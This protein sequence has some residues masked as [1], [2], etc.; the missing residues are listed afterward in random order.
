MRVSINEFR[1]MLPRY[2]VRNLPQYNAETAWDTKIGSGELRCLK[3]D[4]RMFR[5]PDVADGERYE[6]IYKY[7]DGTPGGRWLAWTDFVDLTPGPVDNDAYNRMYLTGLDKP[8]FFDS[9]MLG[10]A[11]ATVDSSNSYS[12]GVTAPLKPTMEVSGTGTGDT[13]S[14]SYLVTYVRELADGRQD[15]SGPSPVATRVTGE[16]FVDVASGQTVILT[17]LTP[18]S[19]TDEG[20]I[21]YIRVYRT[22]TSTAGTAMY[23]FVYEFST[24]PSE[25]ATYTKVTWDGSKFTFTDDV[26]D[27]DLAEALASTDWN[28]PPDNLSGLVY[29]RNGVMAGFVGNDVYFCEPYKPHAWPTKYKL[30]MAYSI[31]GLGVFGNNLVICTDAYP[32]VASVKTPDSVL[33]MPIN[34]LAP[35]LSK[36]SIV[37]TNGAVYYATSRGL[38]RIDTSTPTLVTHDFFLA[39]DWQELNP[40]S[41]D[42]V[43]HR[44]KYLVFFENL[45]GF[46]GGMIIEL[47]DQLNGVTYISNYSDSAFVEPSTDTL[48]MVSRISPQEHYVVKFEGEPNMRKQTVWKSKE[49]TLPEG[50]GNMAAA[51]VTL[52]QC[53]DNEVIIDT[54]VDLMGELGGHVIG[55]LPVAGDVYTYLTSRVFGASNTTFILYSDGVEVYKTVVTD[56]EP[57]RLPS[58]YRGKSIQI[59]IETTQDIKSVDIATSMA[60]LA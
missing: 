60:E 34:E 27:I 45:E 46:S 35:C 10:E 36:N 14:R 52:N 42:A 20:P 37:N 17:E 56:S 40:A 55:T 12:L 48:Y 11:D 22:I 18:S 23:R 13:T 31:V 9:S 1:G 21:K 4:S 16:D 54:T 25:V 29:L 7:E 39:D 59:Q 26:A 49:F 3:E 19:A 43:Y 38:I 50:I 41:F 53:C 33:P 2:G 24:D 32:H 47:A 58:G 28:T 6:T 8:R 51:R 44:G 5:L 30:T 57:F 15:E